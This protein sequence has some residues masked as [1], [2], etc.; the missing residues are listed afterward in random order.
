MRSPPRVGIWVQGD[1][2]VGFG[3][4]VRMQVLARTLVHYQARVSFFTTRRSLAVNVLRRDRWPVQE[5]PA[6]PRSA[7]ARALARLVR[8]D[9]I[10]RLAI[11]LPTALS[12]AVVRV[13]RSCG[14]ALVLIDD[15][16]PARQLVDLTINDI[17][18]QP[19]RS[20]AAGPGRALEGPR[21]M[22]LDPA[23]QRVRARPV[24]T[25][26]RSLLL[27]F[28]GSDPVNLTAWLTRALAPI[29]DR[30]QITCL[31]GPGY[32]GDDSL[33]RAVAQAA[34]RV[35]LVRAPTNRFR[36]F[37]RF[38]VVVTHMG[39]TAYELA[40]IGVPAI[41]LN[42]TQYHSDVADVLAKRGFVLQLGFFRTATP[43]RVRAAIERL[44]ADPERRRAMVRAGQCGVDGRGAE[45][46]VNLILRT[47]RQV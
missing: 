4:L 22:I 20:A 16:G 30:A 6:T 11:D 32:R 46:V 19:Y 29:A 9:R 12:L 43:G 38:D 14:A 2:R 5:L 35:R 28:G 25:E 45:R 18:H 34:G 27:S 39:I 8:R 42:P 41:T 17:D 40:R 13:L 44:L 47:K 15:L 24:R 1:E 36:F 21:Y 33:A 37:T 23:V 31:L 3:H 10:E 26:G 7:Q